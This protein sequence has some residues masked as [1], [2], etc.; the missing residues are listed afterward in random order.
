MEKKK[1][2][3]EMKV[4]IAGGGIAGLALAV[5]L[6]KKGIQCEVYEKDGAFEERRQGYGL[7][8]QQ[9]TLAAREIGIAEQLVAEDTPSTSHY[10]FKSDGEIVGFFGPRF[11]SKEER[12][13]LQKKKRRRF[14]VHTPRQ[15]LRQLIW[16]RLKSTE[17]VVRWSS[18]VKG[19]EEDKHGVSVFFADGSQH[20]VD[21]LVGADGIFSQVRRQRQAD[22]LCYLGVLVVL[23][24]VASDHALLRKRV[25]QT[26]D[27]TTRLFVMPF[28]APDTIMWQLSFPVHQQEEA[29]R[30]AK[31]PHLLLQEAQ[32]RCSGW[33]EPIPELFARTKAA[34]VC[35]FP[36]C[37]RECLQPQQVG[38]VTLIGDA[39]HPMSPFKGQGANQAML[40]AVLLAQALSKHGVPGL[41]AFEA[42]MLRR[43]ASKVVSSRRQVQRLHS[44][45]ALSTEALS[46]VR[47]VDAAVVQ[48]PARARRGALDAAAGR[49]RVQSVTCRRGRPLEPAGACCSASSW[50]VRR[51][52]PRR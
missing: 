43:S 11:A 22:E 47:G 51:L 26:V 45:Q 37:D 39:A 25:W 40:D 9:G 30:L 24:I 5:A 4:G 38:R 17:D 32:R 42:E 19:Y 33:H 44:E 49:G 18:K 20:R 46:V 50:C 8:M 10:I 2:M 15:R 29:E 36:V 31:Q 21:V 34:D 52:R 1:K 6:R 13:R 7:T 41:T 35:G 23:G 28:E 3:D 12:Q 16:N 27:G 48:S 14:N